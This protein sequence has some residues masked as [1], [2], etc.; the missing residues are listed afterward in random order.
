MPII[1]TLILSLVILYLAYRTKFLSLPFKAFSPPKPTALFIKN[2]IIF[3]LLALFAPP[4]LMML[5]PSTIT[6]SVILPTI[7]TLVLLFFNLQYKPLF[8]SILKQKTFPDSKSIFYDILTGLITFGIAI[9]AYLFANNLLNFIVTH[10]LGPIKQDQLAVEALKQNP[11]NLISVI[12]LAPL[13]EEFLFRGLLQN[14]IRSR[15]KPLTSITI[16][17]LIF[18]LFHFTVSQGSL[19]LV[20]LPSLFIFSLFLGFAYEKTRSLI[21]SI[22]LHSTFNTISAIYIL[23]LNN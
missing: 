22:T 6:I 18:A 13:L 3:I 9:F 4:F 23:Y 11:L 2:F 21:T 8:Y 5:Y 17:S 1:T 16:T 14:S 20:L 19:N 7:I 15:L 12:I 10:L